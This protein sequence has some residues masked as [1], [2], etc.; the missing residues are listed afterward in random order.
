MV[1][2]FSQTGLPD[3]PNFRNAFAVAYEHYPEQPE[4]IELISELTG[5]SADELFLRSRVGPALILAE[6][7]DA[8]SDNVAAYAMVDLTLRMNAETINALSPAMQVSAK[9]LLAFSNK[10]MAAQENNDDLSKAYLDG[11]A[12]QQVTPEDFKRA[13]LQDQISDLE[14]TRASICFLQAQSIAGYNFLRDMP[15]NCR[16]HYELAIMMSDSLEV[17]DAQVGDMPSPLSKKYQTARHE[18]ADRIVE[19]NWLA[20]E[21]YSMEPSDA[22]LC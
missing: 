15:F 7:G 6:M 11:M 13:V 21:Q 10:L 19:L 1:L 5:W 17:T 12:E 18:V 9:G 8:V 16:D 20:D 4:I 2:T 3:R 14:M 22:M